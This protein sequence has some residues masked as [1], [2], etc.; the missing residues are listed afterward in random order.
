M[1]YSM[2][3]DSRW[4][5]NYTWNVSDMW[6]AAKPEKGI[7]THYGMTGSE[8]IVTLLEIYTYMIEHRDEMLE[9]EPDNGW[10]DYYG[11]LNFVN[12]LIIE[13]L[14]YP[15]GVWSGD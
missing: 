10:G 14:Q 9:M 3:I 5:H 6:Y 4:N 12:Q 13:S 1:S 7:R 2:G 15:D 11:A 8:A